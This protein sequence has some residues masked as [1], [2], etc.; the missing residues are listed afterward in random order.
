MFF[1]SAL[2]I[3][4]LYIMDSFLFYFIYFFLV[5]DFILQRSQHYLPSLMLSVMWSCHKE[6]NLNTPPLEYRLPLV[7]CYQYNVAWKMLRGFGDRVRK[8]H[9]AFTH[10]S[11]KACSLAIPSPTAAS[12]D[13]PAVLWEA[14]PN[15]VAMGRCSGLQSSL[16]LSFSHSSPTVGYVSEE[17]SHLGSKSSSP[18]FCSCWNPHPS[19]ESTEMRR[20]H[21]E[22]EKSLFCFSFLNSRPIGPLYSVLHHWVLISGL[23]Q[24]GRDRFFFSRVW[25]R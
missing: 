21:G 9:T 15:G 22:A 1:Y 16:G 8:G 12:H 5:A 4:H 17:G 19:F 24:S 3:S 18:S 6:W 10:L 11:W 13:L 14:K 25:K 2:C 20:R 7:I 23:S